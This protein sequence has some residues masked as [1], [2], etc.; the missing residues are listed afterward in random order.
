MRIKLLLAGIFLLVSTHSAVAAGGA[1]PTS[2][3]YLNSTNPASSLVTLS[4][5]GITSCY[6]IAANGSDSN[7]GTSE[8]T[9]WLHAPGMTSCTGTCGSNSPSGGNGYIFPGSDH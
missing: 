2:A 1:C 8:T 7:N 6:Y 9:P 5:L 3:S 4:S